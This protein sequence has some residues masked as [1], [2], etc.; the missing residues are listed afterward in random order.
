MKL[1][2]FMGGDLVDKEAAPVLLGLH[3]PVDER[4]PPAALILAAQETHRAIPELRQVR[5][6]RVR[7]AGY[8]YFK[9]KRLA[10]VN[11]VAG[12]TDFYLWRLR[13][14]KRQGENPEQRQ[15]VYQMHGSHGRP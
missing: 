11:L 4:N 15:R 12:G 7:G 14:G 3:A 1:A 2:A 5:L 13:R 9:D 8:Q 6:G 10:N